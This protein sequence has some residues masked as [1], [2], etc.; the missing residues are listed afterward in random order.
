LL[1]PENLDSLDL[2]EIRCTPLRQS[3]LILYHALDFQPVRK[4]ETAL[5]VLE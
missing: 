5:Q 3:L 4:S 2:I 1:R